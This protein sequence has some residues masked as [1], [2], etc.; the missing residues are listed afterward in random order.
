MYNLFKNPPNFTYRQHTYTSFEMAGNGHDDIPKGSIIIGESSE[1]ESGKRLVIVLKDG[2]V[3]CKNVF[4]NGNLLILSDNE[5]TI[6][7]TMEQVAE[8]WRLYRILIKR[9]N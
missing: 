2:R 1:V 9:E 4:I 8:V 6:E 5:K 3:L 7:T